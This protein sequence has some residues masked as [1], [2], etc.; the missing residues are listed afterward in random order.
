MQVPSSNEYTPNRT[1][2]YLIALIDADEVPDLILKNNESHILY[3][4]TYAASNEIIAP[5]C[6]EVL[7]GGC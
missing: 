4:S 5:A 3:L 2:V 6:R 1:Y 7:L